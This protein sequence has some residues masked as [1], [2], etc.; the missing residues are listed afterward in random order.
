MLCFSIQNVSGKCA[1]VP[2]L[3]GGLRTDGFMLG[4]CRIMLDHARIGRAVVC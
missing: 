1:K 3:S 4:S 2:R